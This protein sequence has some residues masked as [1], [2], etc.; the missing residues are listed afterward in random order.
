LARQDADHLFLSDSVDLMWSMAKDFPEIVSVSSI[1]K[2]W[3]ER[4]LHLITIDAFDYLM[5]DASTKDVL[6]KAHA[7]KPEKHQE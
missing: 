7:P 4:E 6:L 3:E 5:K 1:G 2:S